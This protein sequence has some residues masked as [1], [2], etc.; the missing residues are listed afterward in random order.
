MTTVDPK[1]D[2]FI[3]KL[4]MLCKSKKNPLVCFVWKWSKTR[5]DCS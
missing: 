1:F 5:K 2:G 3:L 4:E